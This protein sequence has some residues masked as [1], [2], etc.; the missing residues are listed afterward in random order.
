MPRFDYI[1]GPSNPIADSISHNFDLTWPV[2][3]ANIM[4]FLPQHNGLQVWTL[5]GQV[6]SAL[7]SALLRKQSKQESL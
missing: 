1:S 4:P 2:Q 6:V 5:S 3:L 7:T